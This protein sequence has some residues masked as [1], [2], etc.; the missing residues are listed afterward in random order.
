[1]GLKKKAT[2][3]SKQQGKRGESLGRLTYV[4]V[5]PP[6][7]ESDGEYNS[8]IVHFI[9]HNNKVRKLSEKKRLITELEC[10]KKGMWRS[11]GNIL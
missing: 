11:S 9:T 5:R 10:E 4:P 6:G 7:K 2:I 1:V 3:L 8:S